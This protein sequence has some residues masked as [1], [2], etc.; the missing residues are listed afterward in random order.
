M[1]SD[2]VG[3]PHDFDFLVG[4]WHIDNR[5]LRQRHVGS[6]DWHEFPATLQAFGH[7]DGIVS[8]DETQFPTEGFSGCT[9]RT[10]DRATKRWAIYWINSR[11]GV[12][13]PPVQGGFAGDRGEFVGDD[14]DEGRPVQVKFVWTRGQ[15]EAR[16]E[17]AF[18]LDGMAW[19][20]N[21][22]MAM[23]RIG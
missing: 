11:I 14:S 15:D 22:I 10:L 12:M 19:E 7:L 2:F 18:S 17:Q 3:Q 13:F 20:T 6:S 23:R 5:R 16:W 4:R 9:V 1:S 8:V 21:W